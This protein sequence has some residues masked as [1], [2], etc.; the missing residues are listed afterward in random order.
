M[1]SPADDGAVGNQ[2]D[3]TDCREVE[4][5]VSLPSGMSGICNHVPLD[6]NAFSEH[7]GNVQIVD[8]IVIYIRWRPTP[9]HAATNY[10]EKK[11]GPE[12]HFFSILAR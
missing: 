2:P 8:S 7:L 4:T 3:G 11:D 5:D 6:D 9:R 1:P 12:W 10:E